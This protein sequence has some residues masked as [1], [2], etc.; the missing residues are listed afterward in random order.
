MDNNTV[1]AEAA[2]VCRALDELGI[3]FFLLTHP[4]ANSM[5]LCR[6]IGEEYGAKHCKNLFLTNRGGNVFRL[7]MMEADKPF[8]TSAVSRSLGVS[9]MSFASAEQLK[10]VLGLEPGCVSVMGLLN[11]GSS[12][13]AYDL[14]VAI[15]KDLLRKE[16]ICVHPN[17]DTATL[18]VN[19]RDVLKFIDLMGF[20]V[21][22]I[23]I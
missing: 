18:V 19:T 1:P 2:A 20:S 21:T 22:F 12:G 14:S 4:R 17:I 16:R 3:G 23:D 8:R 5:E 10:E 13:K 6:G 11:A 9:R 15:D 7:L